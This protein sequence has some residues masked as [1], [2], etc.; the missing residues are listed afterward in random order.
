MLAAEL[1]FRNEWEVGA[2]YYLEWQS[3]ELHR[4]LAAGVINLDTCGGLTG[5]D[6]ARLCRAATL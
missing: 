3:G 4:K 2:P 6:E 1:M 5:F